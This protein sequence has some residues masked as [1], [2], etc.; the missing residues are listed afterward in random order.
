MRTRLIVI[1]VLAWFILL[2]VLFGYFQFAGFLKS[3]PFGLYLGSAAGVV[4]IMSV[5]AG[6]G[7]HLL[8][9]QRID[10]G[11][12]VARFAVGLAALGVLALL[13]C[14]IGLLRVYVVWPV[15]AGLGLLSYKEMSRAWAWLARFRLPRLDAAGF[16]VLAVGA[17]AALVLLINCLAPL[18]ATDALV[19]H[20][21]L[22]KIYTAAGGFVR[23]PYN[24]YANMPNYG[25]MLY[26]LV[27]CAAGETG[28][29][30]SYFLIVL[31][32]AAAIF[33]LA[34]RLV[35]PRFAA[36]GAACF[37]VEPLVLD[38]RVVCNVDVLLMFFLVAAVILLAD[39]LGRQT[40]ERPIRPIFAA[41]SLGGFML[42]IKYTAIAP[43]L[44]LVALP[45]FAFR[46]RIKIRTF[47][48]AL[49]IAA[50]VFAPWLVK[51]EVYVGNPLYPMFSSSLDGVNWDKIRETELVRW[52]RSMGMGRTALDYVLLPFNVNTR[53][54][55]GY[56]RFDGTLAPVLLLLVPLAFV[57]RTRF[58]LALIVMM[59]GIS[60][61]WAFS[62]Q[63]MRFL[64]PSIGLASVLAAAGLAWLNER[65]GIRAANM[66]MVLAALLGAFSLVVPDPYGKAFISGAL[67]D[68]IDVVVGLESREAYLKRNIQPFDMF[69][70]VR[71]YL[72]KDEPLFMIAENRAYYLDNPYFADSF[73]EAST[74]MRMVA[75]ARGP[76]EL[77]QSIR[78]MG[79]NY[80]LINS[81]LV[82][83]FSR[84]Y[85][86]GDVAKLKAFIDQELQPLHSANRLT[87]YTLRND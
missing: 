15:L 73:Y 13:L 79:F 64:L 22:P 47:L 53:G 76:Q 65:A 62:S 56:D 9:E 42:G 29:R 81:W 34:R 82:D 21:N 5:A 48:I 14:S 18:T 72:P 39:A 38:N 54:N 31:A 67:G 7:L 50:A 49:V 74:A 10:A 17:A 24:V 28:A 23:L 55:L 52:Q 51:N 11:T 41:A 40:P 69:D 25:E 85:S 20:L 2:A 30:I 60:V 86:A 16:V 87:L 68:R 43:A 57:K 26:T 45:L 32:T 59:L 70:Y 36:A 27:F 33:A 37:L 71:Q 63:Q 83:Y 46:G 12:L 35:G 66:I 8:P 58:T 44:S 84:Y 78:A 1:A 19:Y 3:S 4:A 61:F 75:Q 80:V 6:L 77:G